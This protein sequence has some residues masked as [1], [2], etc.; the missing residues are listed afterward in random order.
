MGACNNKVLDTRFTAKVTT[1]DRR[2]ADTKSTVW[3]QL[4]DSAGKKSTLTCL[5]KT[6]K[7]ELK[8]GE[9][10]TYNLSSKGLEN[11]DDIAYIIVK[12]ERTPVNDDNWFLDKIVVN[13]HLPF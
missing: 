8:C 1:G 11:P 2:D 6:F 3:M 10:H 13:I 9:T 12:R 4:V 5:D 7:G